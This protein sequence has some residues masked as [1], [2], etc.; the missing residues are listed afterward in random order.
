M[1]ANS[2]DCWRMGGERLAIGWRGDG[3]GAEGNSEG[4]LPEGALLPD[5]IDGGNIDRTAS[6]KGG[7]RQT[8]DPRSLVH[9]ERAEPTRPEVPTI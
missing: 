8:Q 7:C 4:M 6:H 5:Q 1:A 2:R 9:A 3:N